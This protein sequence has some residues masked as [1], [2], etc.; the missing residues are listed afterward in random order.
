M[1]HAL[2]G[3]FAMAALAL[4]TEPSHAAVISAGACVPG[5][6]ATPCA[7]GGV[8]SGSPP[9]FS[10]GA[11][12]TGAF[13]WSGSATSGV[14]GTSATF[15][16]QTIQVSTTGAGGLLDVYFTI[17]GVPTQGLPLAFTST[18]TS[19]QQNA[20]THSVI[21]STWEDNA[22]GSFALASNLA[23]ATLNN[24]V[25]ETAGPDVVVLTPG[26]PVSFTELYQIELEGCATQPSGICTGNLTIDLSAS[27]VPEP[28]SLALLGVGL[29]GLGMVR[30]IRR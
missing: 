2:L 24:A 10:V 7:P 5:A 30:A 17:T 21:E 6:L 11:T 15:N 12:T 22:D 26:S 28:K 3:A 23:S 8:V 1:K 9:L 27:E 18:F 20:V 14:S 16:S 25:L 13:T 19:N 29:L 4:T